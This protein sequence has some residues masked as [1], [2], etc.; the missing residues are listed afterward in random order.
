M[1]TLPE[2]SITIWPIGAPMEKRLTRAQAREVF[3]PYLPPLGLKFHP[4][5]PTAHR[6]PVTDRP[7][8]AREAVQHGRLPHS[9]V[10][11]TDELLPKGSVAHLEK[12]RLR[13]QQIADSLRM[14]AEWDLKRQS[15]AQRA[16]EAF[17]ILINKR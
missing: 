3:P 7:L 13:E 9:Q 17:R 6:H 10:Y 11:T 16:R 8:T 5:A 12:I 1:S 4:S 15:L 2:N 14:A